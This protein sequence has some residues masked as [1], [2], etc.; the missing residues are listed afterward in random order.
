MRNRRTE[1]IRVPPADLILDLLNDAPQKDIE[2]LDFYD[3]YIHSAATKPVYSADGCLKGYFVDTDLVQ[4]IRLELLRSL[5][6]LRRRLIEA[7][8][9]PDTVVVLLQDGRGPE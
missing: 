1:H 8:S 6:V 7:I 4:D 9:A 5:P 2:F 3:G